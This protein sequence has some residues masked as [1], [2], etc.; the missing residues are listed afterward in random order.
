MEFFFKEY[1]MVRPGITGIWQ[2][3]GRNNIDYPER[4][5]MDNWYVHNWSIWLDLV[6]LWRTG[7]VVVA[8]DGAY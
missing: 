5:Q 7:K 6:L 4:V 3:S 1:T 2:T 8:C